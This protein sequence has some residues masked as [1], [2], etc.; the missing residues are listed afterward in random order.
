MPSVH[1]DHPTPQDLYTIS[2]NP[3]LLVQWEDD[4][5]PLNF[6]KFSAISPSSLAL[7]SPFLILHFLLNFWWL[8]IHPSSLLFFNLNTDLHPFNLIPMKTTHVRLL[9]V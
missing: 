2:L 3:Q 9:C 4:C 5:L 6:W 1:L 7:S 8:G